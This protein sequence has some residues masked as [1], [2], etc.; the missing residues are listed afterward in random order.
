MRKEK[1]LASVGAKI[2]DEHTLG[3]KYGKQ[4]KELLCRTEEL[5]EELHIER[6]NRA[7]AEKNRGIL[8]RDIQVAFCIF[9]YFNLSLCFT[10]FVFADMY[11]FLIVFFPFSLNWYHFNTFS[12]PGPGLEAGGS[13]LQHLHP[14]RPEQ[15]AGGRALQA[16]ERP[17]GGQ[18]CSRGHAGRPQAETQQHHVGHGRAD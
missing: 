8:S 5:D 4:V 10:F 14:D 17:G 13:R 1:E 18:H 6:Q 11:F 2:E 16:Q 3:G 12:I 15:E 9:E 7:K